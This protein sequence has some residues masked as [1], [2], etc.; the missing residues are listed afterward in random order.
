MY[1]AFRE[2]FCSLQFLSPADGILP[3]QYKP[4]VDKNIFHC[5][6]IECRSFW[7]AQLSRM[8]SP[9]PERCVSNIPQTM[10]SAQYYIHITLEL[11]SFYGILCFWL[12]LALCFFVLYF[13]FLCSFVTSTIDF[14]FS[15]LFLCL[16]ICVF[17]YFSFL[18]L[19]LRFFI[20]LSLSLSYVGPI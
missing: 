11:L 7:Q 5:S 17:I 4:Y 10:Y 2:H 13:P 19:I 1:I 9:S 6:V 14:L 8:P 15:P 12:C 20:V 18:S 16:F 3:Q